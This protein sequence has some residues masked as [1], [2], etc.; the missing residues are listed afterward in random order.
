MVGISSFFPGHT[1]NRS[2]NSRN[3]SYDSKAGPGLAKKSLSQ[4]P[5]DI[6]GIIYDF[7]DSSQQSD[8]LARHFFI[9]TRL[10][11]DM[12]FEQKISLERFLE[13][14]SN[15]NEVSFQWRKIICL[16]ERQT[17]LQNDYSYKNNTADFYTK[18]DLIL[19]PCQRL[20]SDKEIFEKKIFSNQEKKEIE[21]KIQRMVLTRFFSP[22]NSQPDCVLTIGSTIIFIVI[23]F[24]IIKDKNHL[25]LPKHD[26]DHMS[27][28]F[29]IALEIFLILLDSGLIFFAF[30]NH[31][32]V[33]ESESQ[34]FIFQNVHSF[35]LD[36]SHFGF[37]EQQNQILHSAAYDLLK[38]SSGQK[39]KEVNEF[40]SRFFQIRS[41][42]LEHI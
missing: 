24:F 25:N 39:R 16:I 11:K 37:T 42:P 17:S 4:I 12:P 14:I 9:K 34:I 13:L 28:I 23:L 21:K 18:Y 27:Y 15:Q 26:P 20:I 3:N 40:L 1:L 10:L 8:Q 2:F 6:I 5:T 29:F 41:N 31:K 22:T 38:N 33:V 19:K 32:K 7:L 35:F 30:Q 36:L